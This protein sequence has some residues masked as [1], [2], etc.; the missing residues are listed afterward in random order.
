MSDDK[1]LVVDSAPP[2]P[3]TK[4]TCPNC[5]AVHNEQ[6]L[7]RMQSDGRSVAPAPGLEVV[8]GECDSLAAKESREIVAKPL[9]VEGTEGVEIGVLTV[10]LVKDL[11]REE[12]VVHRERVRMDSVRQQLDRQTAGERRL[13]G[14]GRTRD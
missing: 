7:A 2:E 1:T 10:L 12:V 8:S 9:D 3:P 11:S 14:R 13:A 4:R 6:E 5:G